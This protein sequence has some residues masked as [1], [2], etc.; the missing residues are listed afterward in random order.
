[1]HD[2]MKRLFL[3]FPYQMDS[4]LLD[5]FHRLVDLIHHGKLQQWVAVKGND[6]NATGIKSFVI[7]R[8]I[9]I[10]C[11]KVARGGFLSL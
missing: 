7:Q 2:R 11:L 1:M 6:Q 9:N 5:M 4:Q 10:A 3:G 8:Q